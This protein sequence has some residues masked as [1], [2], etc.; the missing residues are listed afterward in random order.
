MT[1]A[2]FTNHNNLTLNKCFMEMHLA[3]PEPLVVSRR[4][5]DAFEGKIYAEYLWTNPQGK[6]Y[7]EVEPTLC[8]VT[9]VSGEETACTSSEEF[10]QLIKQYMED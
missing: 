4:V 3:S 7:W 2:T 5:V 10:D 9:G 1:S 6:Q 8:S